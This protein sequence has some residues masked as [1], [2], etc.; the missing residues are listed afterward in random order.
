M[1]TITRALR[2]SAFTA[3]ISMSA[4]FFLLYQHLQQ[5]I[6]TLGISAIIVVIGFSFI[7]EWMQKKN[8][9][10]EELNKAIDLTRD[11]VKDLEER[12]S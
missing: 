3:I 5:L 11:Y 12:Y 6:V 2:I 10:V 4:Y 9:E 1:K 8:E 7:Y